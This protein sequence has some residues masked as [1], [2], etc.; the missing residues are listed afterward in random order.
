MHGKA[1]RSN[2]EIAEKYLGEFR[3]FVNAGGY[4]TQ[5]VYCCDETGLF[6][7]KDA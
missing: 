4:F 1:A 6:W 3:D 5:Q 7:K 2:K